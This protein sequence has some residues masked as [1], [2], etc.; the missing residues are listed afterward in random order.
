MIDNGE[1]FDN[2]VDKRILVMFPTLSF[3]LQQIKFDVF[4]LVAVTFFVGGLVQSYYSDMASSAEFEALR[5]EVKKVSGLQNTLIAKF[6]NIDEIVPINSDKLKELD[7]EIGGIY[8]T[9]KGKEGFQDLL[10]YSIERKNS[11]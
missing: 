6:G 9:L 3:N 11:Q 4:A 10:I 1:E 2:A 8:F 7:L 5:I